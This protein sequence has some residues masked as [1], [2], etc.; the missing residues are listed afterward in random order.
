[1]ILQTRRRRLHDA[2]GTGQLTTVSGSQPRARVSYLA[3]WH[4]ELGRQIAQANYGT[5]ADAVLTRPAT[6]PT[7]SDDVLVSEIFYSDAGEAFKTIDASGREDR[8]EFDDA[9]RVTKV[10]ENYTDGD[11]TTGNADEDRTVEFTYNADG[12]QATIK[13]KQQSVS[14]DQTT[15]YV[16]GTAGGWGSSEP[17]THHVKTHCRANAP[18]KQNGSLFSAGAS[19]RL[20]HQPPGRC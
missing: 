14:D 10:I 1:M 7:R 19:L 9:G 2:T 6:V 20:S 8:Q 12:L 5:N 4:D 13:A 16:Y 3:Y 15:T 11:P 17:I 18:A